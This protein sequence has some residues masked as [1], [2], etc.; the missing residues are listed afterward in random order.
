MAKELE[1]KYPER[2]AAARANSVILERKAAYREWVMRHLELT[3][4]S[5]LLD[6]SNIDKSVVDQWLADE[7]MSTKTRTYP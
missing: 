3:Y 5:L 6:L 1:E 4:H 2:A 7:K